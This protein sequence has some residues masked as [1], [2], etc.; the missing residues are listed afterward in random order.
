MQNN[1]AGE[2]LPGVAR[3]PQGPPTYCVGGALS[4][5]KPCELGGDGSDGA[6]GRG[7][8]DDVGVE[9]RC[10]ELRFRMA[11]ADGVDG[12]TGRFLRARDDSADGPAALM[13]GAT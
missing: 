12:G 10:I 7:N 13:K 8:E 1:F 4:Y 3:K 2:D 11:S 6:V 5:S 9:Y